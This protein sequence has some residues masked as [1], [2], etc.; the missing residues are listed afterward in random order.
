MNS[1]FH[2]F[3]GLAYFMQQNVYQARF[4][5]CAA[6]WT[7]FLALAFARDSFPVPPSGPDLVSQGI[8]AV[9]AGDFQTADDDFREAVQSSGPNA[10]HAIGTA[11]AAIPG[12]ELR[13]VC[14]LAAYLAVQPNGPDAAE[15]RATIAQL[16]ARRCDKTL[17]LIQEFADECP[18]PPA[19]R[20]T[21]ITDP[22]RQ[23]AHWDNGP[24]QAQEAHEERLRGFSGRWVQAADFDA[25][26]RIIG[27]LGKIGWNGAK[28]DACTTLVRGECNE[29]VRRFAAGD[30]DGAAHLLADAQKD[31]SMKFP[32]IYPDRDRPYGIAMAQLRMARELVAKGKFDDARHFITTTSD[33]PDGQVNDDTRGSIA[34]TMIV[35]ARAQLKAG[36]REGGA[37]HTH[38]RRADRL[39]H[40]ED[41]FAAET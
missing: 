30:T 1:G 17:Q 11:E 24:T 10:Y 6:F 31:A 41:R 28:S 35:L 29:A 32:G 8:A 22:Y 18:P 40:H 38:R 34:T 12:R 33:N 39:R 5:I 21:K 4:S 15:T 14:W 25:A 7:A 16:M 27:M 3:S 9:Q 13:A 23:K 19:P 37:C 26:R 20:G 36:D 2:N